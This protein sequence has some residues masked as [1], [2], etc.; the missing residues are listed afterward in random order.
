M[1]EMKRGILVI[2][3]GSREKEWVERV[4]CA[5]Q[6]AAASPELRS[7]PI[8]SA[9]LEIVEGR[10]IQDGI[11][12][13]Y[14]H[15]V[16]DMLV[17]PLFVSSGSTHVEEIRQAFGFEPAAHLEGDL[18]PLRVQGQISFGRPIDAGQE[19]AQLLY[20]HI[21]S[22]SAA[23][24]EEALLLIAHGSKEPVFQELYV[25]G[26]AL[27]A[28]QLQE[29]GGF[30][31]SEYALLLPDQAAA[32]LTAMNE[33]HP[34]DTVIVVPIFLSQGYFTNQVIPA[35]LNGLRY[36]YNGRAMLPHPVVAQWLIRQSL[37]WL[38]TRKET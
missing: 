9:F 24:S 16:T 4:D 19:I 28:G 26:L 13:L 30:A 8:V 23:P 27:L 20:D 38:N 10:L 36:R 3:H 18:E 11:D 12:E 22:L 1:Y 7:I 29:L 14:R 21:G 35:R 33:A 5:V 25:Q 6:E 17:I 15:G 2:S 32:K 34:E 37:D 31:R